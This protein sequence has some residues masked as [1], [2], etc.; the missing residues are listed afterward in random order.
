MDNVVGLSIAKNKEKS[1]SAVPTL[2]KYESESMNED[3]T[4]KSLLEANAK[5]L[6]F[7]LAVVTALGVVSAVVYKFAAYE[8]DIGQLQKTQKE[9]KEEIKELRS[10]RQ[11]KEINDAKIEGYKIGKIEDDKSSSGSK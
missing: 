5:V 1:N 11:V 4:P 9:L 7:L 3:T 6:G 8:F 2:K 10:W